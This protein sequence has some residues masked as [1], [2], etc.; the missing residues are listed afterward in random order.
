LCFRIGARFELAHVVAYAR[1]AL[2]AAVLI[3]K[4]LHLVCAHLLL[5]DQVEQDAGIDLAGAR[6]HRQAVER[7]TP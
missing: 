7:P 5:I 2:E 1:K 4:Q 6:A 3:E